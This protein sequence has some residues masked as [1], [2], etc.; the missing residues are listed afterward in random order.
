MAKIGDVEVTILT[1]SISRSN[2][3]TDRMVE[4]GNITDNIK[5]LPDLINLTGVV[6]Q[7]GWESLRK[8]LAYKKEGTLI[9][10]NGRNS[11]RNVAIETLDTDHPYSAKNGFMFTCVLKQIKTSKA[12]FVEVLIPLKKTTNAGRQA[13]KKKPANSLVLNKYVTLERW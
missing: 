7:D 11:Y 3:I 1:E 5:N 10:Y 9:D 4:D 8:L 6:G 13:T 2:E 12:K